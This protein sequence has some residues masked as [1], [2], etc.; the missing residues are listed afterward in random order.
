MN[1]ILTTPDPVFYISQPTK[2]ESH[3]GEYMAN[4]ISTVIDEVG[5]EK[6]LSCVTDNASNMKRLG[7][8]LQKNIS[9][10]HWLYCA[11]PEPPD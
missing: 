5:P 9:M 8:Y 4:L 10:C 11:F 3:T 1:F 7:K 2:T 6:V